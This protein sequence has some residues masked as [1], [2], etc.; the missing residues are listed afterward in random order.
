VVGNRPLE[1]WEG[2][3]AMVAMEATL[4]TSAKARVMIQSAALTMS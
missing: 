1:T 2:A 4:L 3:A